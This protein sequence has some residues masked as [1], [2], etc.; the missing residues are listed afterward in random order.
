MPRI[1]YESSEYDD[2][3]IIVKGLKNKTKI[4]IE[5]IKPKEEIK[6]E[7]IEEVK[8]LKE[9]IKKPRSDKQIE[10][11]LKMREMLKLKREN[12][13]KIKEQ[14]RLEHDELKQK[15]KDKIKKNNVNDKVMKKIKK[16]VESSSDEEEEEEEIKPIKKK[17]PAAPKIKPEIKQIQPV[18][19]RPQSLIRFY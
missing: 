12:E 16:I 8:P 3:V 18:P 6:Q 1:Q 9:K 13:F 11:T 15:I 10:N 7:I 19:Q 2:D 14:V 4:P 17:F 5:E